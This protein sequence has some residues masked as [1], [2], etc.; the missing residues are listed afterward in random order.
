MLVCALNTIHSAHVKRKLPLSLF[1]AGGGGGRR[2]LG[3]NFQRLIVVVA[4]IAFQFLFLRRKC[5]AQRFPKDDKRRTRTDGKSKPNNDALYNAYFLRGK[6]WSLGRDHETKF[7]NAAL[8]SVL[9]VSIAQ[10]LHILGRGKNRPSAICVFTILKPLAHREIG[11]RERRRKEKT[12]LVSIIRDTR[13]L[14]TASHLADV[15]HR[16]S[17]P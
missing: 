2:R 6:K 8:K 7:C 12:H 1:R 9:P 10:I 11:N 3:R 13:T 5:E 14:E 15:L 16:T 4:S 17:L